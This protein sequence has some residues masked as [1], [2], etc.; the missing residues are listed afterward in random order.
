MA[1][2]GS[3][4]AS[5]SDYAELG[6]GPGALFDIE[7]LQTWPSVELAMREAVKRARLGEDCQHSYIKQETVL[8]AE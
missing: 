7:D 5:E 3:A 2:L 8:F 1:P 4:E 6:P